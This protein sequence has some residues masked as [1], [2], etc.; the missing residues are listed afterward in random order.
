MIAMHC[1]VLSSNHSVPAQGTAIRSKADILRS[2]Q[3]GKDVWLGAGVIV[4]GGVTIGDGAVIGAGSV[5]SKDIPAGAICHGTPAK[6]MRQR[7][8]E[9]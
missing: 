6:P 4:L 8:T 7:E 9:Q 2:T 1:C 3:I 5:V